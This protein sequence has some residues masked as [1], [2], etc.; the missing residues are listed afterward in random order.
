MTPRSILVGSDDSLIITDT[1]NHRIR[2]IDS[3]GVIRTIAGTGAPESSGDGGLAADAAVLYPEYV[4]RRSNGSIGFI[5]SE[6][7][8]REIIPDGSILTVTEEVFDRAAS[9]A[10]GPD[11]SYYVGTSVQFRGVRRVFPDG[12][13]ELVA[14]NGSFP[15]T[16]REGEG[17]PAKQAPIGHPRDIAID[18]QGRLWIVEAQPAGQIR[19]VGID[20]RISTIAGGGTQPISQAPLDALNANLPGVLELALIPGTNDAYVLANS[21][22]LRLKDGRLEPV[23]QLEAGDI[24]VDAA[25]NLFLATGERVLRRSADG[26]TTQVA[27]P[28]RPDYAAAAIAADT[29]AF[30][31]GVSVAPGGDLLLFNRQLIYRWRPGDALVRKIAGNGQLWTLNNDIPALESGFNSIRQVA[32]DGK[33]GVYVADEIVPQ[34]RYIDPAGTIRQVAGTN[35]RENFDQF[36]TTPTPARSVSLY[37]LD[38]VSVGPDGMVYF[39]EASRG[40]SRVFR[41]D[42][43]GM[44]QEYPLEAPA[45]IPN[46]DAVTVGADGTV[47]VMERSL[48]RTFRLGANSADVTPGLPIHPEILDGTPSLALDE[49]G[50]LYWLDNSVL[51]RARSNGVTER[52]TSLQIGSEAEGASATQL[53]IPAR[54]IT[55]SPSGDLLFVD[56]GTGRVRRIRDVS[57][58]PGIVHPLITSEGVVNAAHFLRRGFLSPG[59]IVSLF[60]TNLG[61]ITPVTGRF[62]ENGRLASEVAGVR[63]L[64]DGIP[65]PI[66]FASSGQTNFVTPNEIGETFDVVVENNGRRSD[67]LGSPFKFELFSTPTAPGLFALDYNPSGWQA[68]ALN[69]D[70]S[71]NG[72]SNPARPGEVI[73]LYGTGAG[74]MT[75]ELP[76][77]SIVGSDLPRIDG[78]VRVEIGGR[79]AKVAYAGGAP[80]LVYGVAQ[81]NAVIPADLE[82]TG[83]VPV[84]IFV[85][86]A[87]SQRNV[88]IEV[89]R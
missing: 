26:V 71:I 72:P 2:R 35:R 37:D 18:S 60:G 30:W 55:A 6:G 65:A 79:D 15:Q 50:S 16:P 14:G 24:A 25:G 81:I 86:S 4:A 36:V 78:E 3:Q 33:D 45:R 12:R 58:C 31:I 76:N 21:R 42:A 59:E 1:R 54:W 88:V 68:A 8:L 46:A 51:W 84:Q 48:A 62:D 56:Q 39:T 44:L 57:A 83:R 52:I 87:G 49:D 34:L 23:E 82:T 74:K 70:T 32:G 10:A 85:E 40:R 9:L 43:N 41:L 53:S 28:P 66:V 29:P 73:V 75:P 7:K 11:G 63:V 27:G 22:L 47:Y 13:L 77:G 89:R 61:P 67:E 20:G 17:L 5:G 64:V 19:R 80:G 69:Q 38:S